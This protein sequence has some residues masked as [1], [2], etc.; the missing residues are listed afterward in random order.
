LCLDGDEVLEPHAIDEIKQTIATT[1]L[2]GFTIRRRE[3]F[4]GKPVMGKKGKFLRLY[5]KS[6]AKWNE[7]RL[8]HEHIDVIGSIGK[9]PITIHHHTADSIETMMR[10]NNQYASLKADYKFSQGK[11]GSAFKLFLAFPLNMVKFYIVRGH[12]ISG[13]N[14]LVYSAITSFYSFLAEANLI[15]KSQ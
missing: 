9:L 2:N 3:Y 13:V 6:M 5:K 4:M 8:V 11:K 15:S 10:K 1:S 14:G 7:D 12:F